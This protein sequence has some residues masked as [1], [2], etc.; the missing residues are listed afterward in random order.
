MCS[1]DLVISCPCALGLATPTAIMVGTGAAARAGILIKDAEA[2]ERAHKLKLVVF[3]K[4]GT[5]TEGR[6]SVS[7]VVGLAASE[8]ETLALAAAV[9]AGSEHP[10]ARGVLA[11]AADQG[12][13]PAQS[14]D[15]KSLTGRGVSAT[16]EARRLWLG[17]RR[18]MAEAGV[19]T[20]AGEERAAAL[21]GEGDTVMWLADD[22]KPL[23][24][25]LLGLIAVRDQIKPSAAEAVARLKRLGIVTVMLTGDNRRSAE[26]VAKAVGVDS[27]VAEVLPEDKAA[28]IVRR[29]EERRVGQECRSRWSRDH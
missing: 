21:E 23:G 2:L 25:K 20:A 29:S 5:L 10:L 14:S 1:S 3:D 27:L 18:L 17:N 12:I 19:D 4:T 8:T 9:Q 13:D 26:I 22:G 16:V 28:E 7:R 15:F 24:A 11:R 6:P